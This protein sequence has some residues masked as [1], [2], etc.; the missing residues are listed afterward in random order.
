MTEK[1]IRTVAVHAGSAPGDSFGA[2]SVPIYQASL[3]TFPNAEE[4]AAIHEGEA[5]GYFYGRMGNPTQ[6]ALERS[7]AELEG[8]EAALA[9]ASGMAAIALALLAVL[10]EGDHLV[11]QASLYTSTAALL[12]E[13]VAPR[14][15]EVSRFDGS[16]AE[17]LEAVLRPDTRAVYLETPTNPTLSVVDVERVASIAHAAGALVI[18]DGTF[19]TP[20]NLRP[21]SLGAD[22]VVHSAT[23]YL[24][25]H[26]DLVAGVL[27]GSQ[28][29]V[30]A[31]RW[32][33][34]RVLGPVIAPHTAWLVQRGLRTLAVRMERHNENAMRVAEFLEAHPNVERVHYPGLASHPQHE[35]ARRQMRG[36]GGMI[37]F[38][39]ADAQAAKRLVDSVRLISLAVSLGDVAS[40]IQHSSSM[41]QSSLTADQQRSAGVNPG[42]I[43]LSVG[44]EDVADII[45]DLEQALRT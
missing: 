25:G 33:M 41:T 43:R 38:E 19:A 9:T 16:R 6:A 31:A 17:D 26:G 44:I 11:A 39:M 40:L 12:D 28:E 42:L 24:G 21:L 35:L 30:D 14:S 34:M 13:I 8:G 37:A 1:R 45:G 20:F 15:V 22:L 29:L 18:V 2:L 10:E 4:G 3:F 5:P 27:V 7:M 36:F 32:R 23:K